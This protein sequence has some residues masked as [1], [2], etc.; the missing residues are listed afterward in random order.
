MSDSALFD[1]LWQLNSADP[2]T[3]PTILSTATSHLMSLSPS[4]AGPQLTYQ[5]PNTGWTSLMLLTIVDGV[6]SCPEAAPLLT[7]MLKLRARGWRNCSPTSV[8]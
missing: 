6:S 8:V 5:M 3:F 4:V 7:L 2:S 1:I